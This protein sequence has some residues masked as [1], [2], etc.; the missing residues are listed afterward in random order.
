MLKHGEQNLMRLCALDLSMAKIML[1]HHN[2]HCKGGHHMT[3]MQAQWAEHV[4]TVRSH[5]AQEAQKI[6]ELDETKRSHLVNES[7]SERDLN[8]K[9]R[10][11]V[12]QDTETMRHNK[13]SEQEIA[14]H[15]RATESIMRAENNIKAMAA[16]LTYQ[17][18]HEKTVSEREVAELKNETEIM[19]TLAQQRINQ[20]NASSQKTQAE[21]AIIS[22]RGAA[23]RGIAALE[24]AAV[25]RDMSTSQKFVNYTQGTKNIVNSITDVADTVVDAKMLPGNIAKQTADTAQRQAQARQ[26]NANAKKIEQQAARQSEKDRSTPTLGEIAAEALKIKSQRSKENG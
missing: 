19:L 20:M 13:V 16:Q 8:E 18:S 23:D 2:D 4:E 22:A 10:H 25:A 6:A 14:D 3:Q 26:A 7:L 24:Q 11:Q 15:N 9:V 5:R 12:F 21:A 17:A 1:V